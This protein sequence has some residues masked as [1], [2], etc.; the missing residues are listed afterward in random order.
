MRVGLE[1][2]W[3]SDLIVNVVNATGLICD[4]PTPF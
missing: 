1:Y 3:V 4:G 2:F